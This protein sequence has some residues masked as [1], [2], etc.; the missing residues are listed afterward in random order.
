MSPPCG[1]ASQARSIPVPGV[2]NALKPLR[3]FKQPDGLKGL[4][5]VDFAR[6]STANCLCDFAAEIFEA[7]CQL[8]KLC[9]VENPVNSFFWC[10]TPWRERTYSHLDVVQDHFA[11]TEV[12]G[13]SKPD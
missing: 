3:S 7:C 8:G 2:S 9:A 10:V 4:A 13:Q 6:V 11:P 1:T 5:G 12:T